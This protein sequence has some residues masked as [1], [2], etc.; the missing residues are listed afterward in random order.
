MVVPARTAAWLERYADL[1][2]LRT[3]YRGADPEVDAVLVALGVAAA[4]WREEHQVPPAGTEVA[5]Q[6]EPAA[7]SVMSSAQAAEALG[8]TDRAVRKAA[9]AGRLAATKSAGRWRIEREDLEL[10]RAALAA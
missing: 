5:A 7:F 3:R 2:A 9:A 10:Y 1:R 4:G 6:P 8:R